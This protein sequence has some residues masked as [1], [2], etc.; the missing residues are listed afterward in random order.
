MSKAR[1]VYP[2]IIFGTEGAAKDI[3]YWLKAANERGD[4]DILEVEGFIERDAS[5]IGKD[6]FGVGKVIASDDNLDELI[7]NYDRLGVII[8]FGNPILRER[9]VKN[10]SKYT[11]VFFPNIIHPSVIYDKDAGTMGIGN[12]IG[13]GVVIESV[14]EFGDFNY[15]SGAAHLGHDIRLGNYNSIN[16]SATTAGYVTFEDRCMLGINATV[17]Q[18]LTISSDITVGAGAVVTKNLVEKGVYT[19]IPAKLFKKG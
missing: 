17:I 13:P 1:K 18:D 11:N 5:A 3:F 4:G 14:Y 6:A 2:A 7:S 19:G 16:P 8:P 15:V 10:I 12:H 9:I